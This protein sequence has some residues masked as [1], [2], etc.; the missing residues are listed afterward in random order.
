MPAKPKTG[1]KSYKKKANTDSLAR[2]LVYKGESEVYG[3]CTKVLGCGYYT[4]YCLDGIRRRCHLRGALKKRRVMMHAGDLVLVSLREF[5]TETDADIVHKYQPDEV[6]ELKKYGEITVDLDE[7]LDREVEVF[8]VDQKDAQR[9]GK[10]DSDNVE[11]DDKE[12]NIDSDEI[13]DL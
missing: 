7:I 12:D 5:S 13:D 9:T 6:K 11:A 2:D 8:R 10:A 1:G 3:V 4:I